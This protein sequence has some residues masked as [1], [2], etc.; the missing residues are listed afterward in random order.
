MLKI[1]YAV[2]VFCLGLT[3][4]ISTQFTLEMRVAALNRKEIH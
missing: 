2:L 1:S 3:P 4:A